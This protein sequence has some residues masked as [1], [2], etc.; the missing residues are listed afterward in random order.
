MFSFSAKPGSD[1]KRK[2]ITKTSGKKSGTT[3]SNRT[4]GERR[5]NRKAAKKEKKL[6]RGIFLLLAIAMCCLLAYE[7]IVV[8]SNS[9]LEVTRKIGFVVS[10]IYLAETGPIPEDSVGKYVKVRR[11]QAIFANS[12]LD[13]TREILENKWVKDVT[14]HKGFPNKISISV[15]YKE[16][17]AVFQQNSKFTII[18]ESGNDIVE[19]DRSDINPDVPTVV[20]NGAKK[21][22]FSFLKTLEGYPTIRKKLNS[23]AYI[24]ERRWNIIVSGG[25]V[26]KLPETDTAAALASL[27]AILKNPDFNRKTV[28][29]I[30]MRQKGYTVMSG[31]K[32]ADA[33]DCSGKKKI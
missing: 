29:I 1:K 26:I 33:T 9:F 28:R 13:I 10:D 8:F 32:I 30:D 31:I 5:T 17:I 6:N 11:R 3:I 15:V 7:G 2:K 20:G 23:M 4:H 14:V 24:R 12:T 21:Q 27:E 18:D 19:I 16:G 22:V 25:I